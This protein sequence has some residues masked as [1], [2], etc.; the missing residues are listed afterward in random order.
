MM[1]KDCPVGSKVRLASLSGYPVK[2]ANW[3]GVFEV[4]QGE[5]G[6]YVIDGDGMARSDINSAFA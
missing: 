4:F 2:F 1:L 5:N 6:K 3:Q